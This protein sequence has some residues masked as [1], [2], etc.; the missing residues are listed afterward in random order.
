M[1][2]DGA[3]MVMCMQAIMQM[4]SKMPSYSLQI[5]M[6]FFVNAGCRP[7]HMA[8]IS[9]HMV[10]PSAKAHYKLDMHNSTCGKDQKQL[11][12]NPRAAG[13]LV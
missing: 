4:F 5:M 8:G 12:V 13:M 10:R 6:Q 1:H 9:S 2:G 11:T 3:C 7:E